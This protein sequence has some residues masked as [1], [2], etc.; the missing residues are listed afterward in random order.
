MVRVSILNNSE[1]GLTQLRN[2]IMF[3]LN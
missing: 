3:D 1:I 2:D